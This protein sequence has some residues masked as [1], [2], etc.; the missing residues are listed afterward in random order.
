MIQYLCLL[1]NDNNLVNIYYH[2]LLQNFSC[3]QNF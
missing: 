3:D 2:T 1:Q